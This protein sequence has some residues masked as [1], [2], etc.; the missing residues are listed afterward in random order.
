MRPLLALAG[1]GVLLLGASSG[2]GGKIPP[3]HYYKLD[4]P[5]APLSSRTEGSA[6]AILMPFR[7]S[8]ML[9]QDKIIYRPSRE[10]VGFYEYH[11]WAEDPRTTIAQS[12]LDHLRQNKTFSRIV[13][14][15]GRTVADYIIRGRI[16]RLEEIDAADGVSVALRISAEIVDVAK[17]EPLWHGVREESLGVSVGQVTAVVSRM[18][19]AASA[20]VAKLAADIDTFVRSGRASAVSGAASGAEAAGD[21]TDR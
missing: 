21:T 16:E 20:G 19:E 1:F 17:R 5:A 3:S 4:L 11:R 10:E 2:C 13:L 18:S 9:A 12:L 7:G 6:T 15:D 8:K 14:F